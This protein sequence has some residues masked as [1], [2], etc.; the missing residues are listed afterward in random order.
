MLR[1][2][3]FSTVMQST[4]R[5][6]VLP[7]RTSTQ[8]VSMLYSQVICFIVS[9]FRCCGRDRF[10]RRCR[11]PRRLIGSYGISVADRKRIVEC[12]KGKSRQFDAISPEHKNGP[13]EKRCASP[14][15]RV[16]CKPHVLAQRKTGSAKAAGGMVMAY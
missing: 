13:A 14:P 2:I 15:G 16:N 9:S 12:A 8:A 11:R 6:R 7:Q 4:A 5:I 10:L 1:G 3:W